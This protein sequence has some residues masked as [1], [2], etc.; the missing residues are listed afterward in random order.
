V[1]ACVI[2]RMHLYMHGWFLARGPRAASRCDCG[3]QRVPR[4]L[5]S[6]AR[7]YRRRAVCLTDRAALMH[8]VDTLSFICKSSYCQPGPCMRLYMRMRAVLEEPQV[9]SRGCDYDSQRAL[10][11]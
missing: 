6:P 3:S 8:M 1:G 10:D 5:G 9:C 7:M 2:A 11:G 4:V